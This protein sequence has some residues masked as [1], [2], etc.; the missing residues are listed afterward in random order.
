[1]ALPITP[2]VGGRERQIRIAAGAVLLL[3]AFIVKAWWLGLLG[4]IL[5]ASGVLRY[6]FI[7][8]LLGRNTCTPEELGR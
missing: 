5:L 2:N 7:N 6:C 8:Q 1:M 4:L 3:L